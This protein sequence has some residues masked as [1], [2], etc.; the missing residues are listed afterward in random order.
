MPHLCACLGSHQDQT[1]LATAPHTHPHTLHPTQTLPHPPPSVL[2]T[3]AP[4]RAYPYPFLNKLPE[5]QGLLATIAAALLLFAGA[6]R[7]G[8]A[9]SVRVCQ[10]QAVLGLRPR[11]T[12]GSSRGSSGAAKGSGGR[13]ARRSSSDASRSDP[14][15]SDSAGSSRSSSRSGGTGGSGAMLPDWPHMA[16]CA[17]TCAAHAIAVVR[18]GGS[19]I[20]CA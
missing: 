16:S 14:G 10:L 19:R 7:V 2:C 18:R 9:L 17:Q 3:P 6:F 4:R 8:K 5:P 11:R 1:A 13:A 15:A 12:H 20:S